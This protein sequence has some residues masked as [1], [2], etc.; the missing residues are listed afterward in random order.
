M[1]IRTLLFSVLAVLA[2]CMAVLGASGQL[3]LSDSNESIRTTYEDRLIPMRDLKRISD[4]YGVNIVDAVH[5]AEMG[6]TSAPEAL[7]SIQEAELEIDRR[8]KSY[9][10]TEIEGPEL[11]MVNGLR[12]L[13][14]ASN[15]LVAEIKTTLAAN[16]RAKLEVLRTKKL[17]QTID[18]VSE[19]IG[20]L[21]DLQLEYA[22]KNSQDAA[23]SY[24]RFQK[25]SIGL[26]IAAALVIGLAVY[27][28]V[29]RIARRISG[30]NGAM[31]HLAGGD[32]QTVIPSTDSRDEIGEMAKSVQVFKDNMIAR[33]RAEA[34]IAAQRAEAEAQRAAREAREAAAIKEISGLCDEI[35]AGNLTSRLNEGD[36]EG[37]LLT[38]SQQLNSLTAMLQAMTGEMADV[39][40][41]LSEG[42]VTRSV[43]GDYHGVFATLKDSV[44]SMSSQL[45]EI[46]FKLNE[47][48]LLVRDASS[49]ISTGS[50]DLA[51]RT[52]SQAAS[53]EETA[54]SMHEITSTV[55]NNA[56]NAQAANQMSVTAR[57]AAE[58]GGVVM[59]NAV[60][61]MGKIEGSAQKI[62]EIV[63][64][65]EEIA[66]QTNLLALNASVEAARA[67]EA[68]KGFAV[69]AQEV[70]SLAQRSAGASKDIKALISDS[71]QQVREGAKYVNEA[72]VA[73]QDIVGSVKKVS[74]IVAEIAA[75]SKEQATGLD[76]INQ[77]V[78]NMDEMTQRNGA[79]VEET[80]ASAQQ[81]AGQAAELASI[82]SFFK[83]DGG[84]PKPV[85][86]AQAVK[87][88]A[89]HATASKPAP[90]KA[91]PK[92]VSAKHAAA[93]RPVPP[94]AIQANGKDDGD[95][96][97]F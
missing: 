52:E 50:T 19:G 23:A 8:M 90:A 76:Q 94:K 82:V 51:Q 84:A 71:N 43:A 3:A 4:M 91:A 68:G 48:A 17:Y 29:F 78:T 20:K 85:V 86:R 73:L 60:S 96:A 16:D 39:T 2:I 83:T 14:A 12:P 21:I 74:D 1:T 33:E 6:Q 77:A 97:E 10:A 28:V 92:A 59:Q 25:V 41:A 34:D 72:E 61:S 32:V 13:I 57:A 66:F 63:G 89:S 38:M 69:V 45:K 47:S 64:M 24:A 18:P 5:K 53:I 67:G 15:A 49:E 65:M 56:E 79:L 30:M 31:T 54:A 40:A 75:A 9:L 36:K 55:K 70:R 26:Y 87:A 37:F 58:K 35:S 88:P 95:W 7:K 42:D 62:A 44:N 11:V 81:L 46:A 27:I 80:S 22:Q 93:S